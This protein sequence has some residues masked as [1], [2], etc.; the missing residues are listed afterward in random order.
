MFIRGTVT[1]MALYI[2]TGILSDQWPERAVHK[3]E[4]KSSDLWINYD[5][6]PVK[7]VQYCRNHEVSLTYC[8]DNNK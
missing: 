4:S 3:L 7:E 1:L 5:Y 8:E 6:I 2:I